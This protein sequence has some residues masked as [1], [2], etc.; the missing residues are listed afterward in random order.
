MSCAGFTRYHTSQQCRIVGYSFLA[1]TIVT[2]I[3]YVALLLMSSF[4]DVQREASYSNHQSVQLSQDVLGI[5]V[6]EYKQLE[7][8]R[9]WALDQE[10]T[11]LSA[12]I[13]VH[14]EELLNQIRL[15]ASNVPSKSLDKSVVRFLTTR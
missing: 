7:I 6:K 12:N 8:Q 2:L 13:R 11:G 10:D 4:L 15:V 9:N 5:M 1:A 3:I 14:Q